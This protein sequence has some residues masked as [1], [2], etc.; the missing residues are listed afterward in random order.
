MN[1][2]RLPLYAV[3][4]KTMQSMTDLIDEY[5]VNELH[6]GEFGTDGK[7]RY[8]DYEAANKQA[9]MWYEQYISKIKEA[10]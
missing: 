5:D 6:A 4:T 10:V 9:V 3:D 2:N 7:Y 1:Y 8:Y